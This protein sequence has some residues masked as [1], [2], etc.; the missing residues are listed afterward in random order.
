MYTVY[1]GMQE[2]E[3]QISSSVPILVSVLFPSLHLRMKYLLLVYYC[4][5]NGIT[6][7]VYVELYACRIA[8]LLGLAFSRSVHKHD[9]SA[10]PLLNTNSHRK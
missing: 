6:T 7:A 2:W 5:P 8:V 10:L 9:Y 4:M 1:S 3:I